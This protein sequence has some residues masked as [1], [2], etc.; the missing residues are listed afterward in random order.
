MKIGLL[1]LGLIWGMVQTATAAVQ[2]EFH[3]TT[4][5]DIESIPNGEFSGKAIID[6]DRTRV[7]FLSGNTYPPGTYVI[8]HNGS[9]QQT[10]VDPTKQSYVDVNAGTVAAAIGSSRISIS[11]KKIDVAQMPDHPMIAGIPTDH[12]R[13]TIS[14]DITVPFG[15]IPLKQTVSTV[16]DKWTT[17]AYEGV[18]DSFF[19]SGGIHTGNP[20]IDDLVQAENTRIK[21]FPLRETVNITTINDTARPTSTQ[22]PIARTHTQTREL[23]ITSIQALA[24]VPPTLFQVPTGFHKANPLR[25]D[26]QKAPVHVLSMQPSQP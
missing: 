3:Q 16:I 2:Y 14:Y 17:Q 9:R 11:N 5:S 1:A 18:V 10:W 20:D 8:T 12:F 7:D 4:Q 15:T 6:G 22:I 23:T 19:S 21:G 24:D 13:M 25:D 26:S